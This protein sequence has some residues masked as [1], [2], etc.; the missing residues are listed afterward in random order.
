MANEMDTIFL[1]IFHSHH[2]WCIKIFVWS[3]QYIIACT[4]EFDLPNYFQHGH[5]G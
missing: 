5:V 2:I 3:V 1:A 4:A